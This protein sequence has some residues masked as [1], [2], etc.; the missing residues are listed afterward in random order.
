MK[1]GRLAFTS[2]ESSQEFGQKTLHR[3]KQRSPG[4]GPR[5]PV[6][7]LGEY[8]R[9]ECKYQGDDEGCALS[10]TVHRDLLLSE[11]GPELRLDIPAAPAAF[12]AH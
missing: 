12:Q 11:K 8:G 3:L 2:P 10:L 1:K 4:V 6:R 5:R 9:C 7:T